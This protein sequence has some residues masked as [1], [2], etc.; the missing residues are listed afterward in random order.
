MNNRSRPRPAT[1]AASY[2]GAG[3]AGP[4]A[5]AAA[6]GRAAA[7]P[8]SAAAAG[9]AS[10]G[11]AEFAMENVGFFHWICGFGGKSGDF[12]WASAD[13]VDFVDLG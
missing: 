4:A 10:A 1:A 12:P 8:C 9:R 11:A 3:R 5:G 6:A 2:R 7:A 13:F